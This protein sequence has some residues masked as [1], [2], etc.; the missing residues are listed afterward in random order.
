MGESMIKKDLLSQLLYEAQAYNRF[1]DIE[2]LV[3]AGGDLSM[4][5]IQPLFVSLQ[6]TSKD[7]LADILPKL[8]SEQRQAIRDIDLWQKDTIDP[9]A[10]NYWLEVYSKCQDE[11]VQ[12]EFIKS[13]DFLL[14]IKNQLT[15]ST[16]DVEDPM[17]P[18]DDY[19]FLTEDNQ[20]LIAYPEDFVLVQ[21]LKGM[22]RKLYADIGVENAYAFLFKMIVDSYQIMEENNYQQK[23]ERLRD[24]GFVDYF[25]SLEYNASFLS[26]DAINN[27]IK[28]KKSMTPEIDSLSS[29]QSLHSTSLVAFQ[30]S[31][32]DIRDAL[33]NIQNEARSKYLHFNFIRLVNARMAY[34]GALKN[35]SL[36]MTKVGHQ[37]RAKLELGFQYVTKMRGGEVALF[38]TFDFFDL[39]KVGHS[40]IEMNQK[41]LKKALSSTAFEKDDFSYFL[42]MYWN[43]FLEHSYS[44]IPSY[45]FDGSSKPQEISQLSI[46]ESWFNFSET[47]IN[48][49]PFMQSFFKTIDALKGNGLLNDQFYLNYEV[50]NI[51]FEAILISSFV[52]FSGGHLFEGSHSKMGVTIQELKTFYYNFFNKNGDEFLIKGEEDPK[53]KPKI[54]E[55]IEKFGLSNIPAFQVYLYQVLVEQLN[56]Y[57]IDVMDEEEFRHIGGPILLNSTKN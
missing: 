37:T 9:D 49:L 57:E 34:L 53:L 47:F 10:A 5:P 55:F 54:I 1:E 21:E 11:L 8:S 18:D 26:L 51:D 12:M 56:G 4:I 28:N 13:E 16:F 43:S 33:N 31:L 44:E 19:Y 20:L 39:F 17:Y 2:K 24:F 27:F 46:Y 40:L 29:S 45:K 3:E 14:A 35:G 32:N 15:I 23:K 50:E 25:D 42:G 48:S 7:Q 22:V 6:N 52:N 30:S 36:A 41:K 38:E